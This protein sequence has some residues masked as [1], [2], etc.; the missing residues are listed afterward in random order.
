MLCLEEEGLSAR[1][2]LKKEAFCSFCVLGLFV[3]DDV[4]AP[5]GEQ[6]MHCLVTQMLCHINL[7]LNVIHANL[8]VDISNSHAM[9]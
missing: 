4:L 9:S 2:C 1:G 5:T 3:P 8:S 6:E 7:Y